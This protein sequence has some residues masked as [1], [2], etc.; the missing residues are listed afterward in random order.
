MVVK[1]HTVM[2]SL[3]NAIFASGFLAKD[4]RLIAQPFDPSSGKLSGELQS[5][6][7]TVANDVSTWHMDVSAST[8]GI[9]VLASGGTAD[10]E[11]TWFDRNGKPIGKA[12]DKLT[13]QGLRP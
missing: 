3:S 10:W 12:A 9:L 6:G 8:T 13:S 4:T 1:D 2:R 5:L 7:D 11:L